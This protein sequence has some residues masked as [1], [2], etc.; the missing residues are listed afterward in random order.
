MMTVPSTSVQVRDLRVLN[1]TFRDAL[2]LS[3]GG[4]VCTKLIQL[5]FYF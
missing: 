1:E 4:Q 3:C 2:D 5:R